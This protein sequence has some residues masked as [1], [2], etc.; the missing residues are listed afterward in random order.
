MA[1]SHMATMP[2]RLSTASQ[3][4]TWRQTMVIT[5]RLGPLVYMASQKCYVFQCGPLD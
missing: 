5:L 3:A 4:E 2:D 1:R